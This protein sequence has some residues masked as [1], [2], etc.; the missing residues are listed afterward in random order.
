[1][2]VKI[3]VERVVRETV[4]LEFSVTSDGE[5]VVLWAKWNGMQW[6]VVQVGLNGLYPFGGLP[7]DFPIQID[8]DTQR[9][10]IVTK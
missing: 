8:P 6:A 3:D 10:A 5:E 4:P 1:M 7:K 9:V 2:S